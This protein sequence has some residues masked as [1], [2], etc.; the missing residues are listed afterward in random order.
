MV[1]PLSIR[2]LVTLLVFGCYSLCAD[3]IVLDGIV[4]RSLANVSSRLGTQ[5]ETLD[6]GKYVILQSKWSKLELTRGSRICRFNGTILYF[7]NEVIEQ[8]KDLYLPELDWQFTLAPLLIS[9]RLSPTQKTLRT[10]VL[11]PGH[12]G[13]DPGAINNDAG[14]FEKDLTLAV[15]L[16]LEKRLKKQGYKVLVTR[17]KDTFLTLQERSTFASKNKAD[18]FISIHFN[19]ASNELARGIEVFAYTLLN[20]PSTHRST[21]SDEDRIFRRANRY[22]ALNILLAYNSQANLIRVTG[23][24]DRG[25]KRARFA[26]IEDIECPGILVELG[27]MQNPETA[28]KLK[29]DAYLQTLAQGLEAGI[30]A[31]HRRL[32]SP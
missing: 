1:K 28:L 29:Q 19:S 8:N 11:D 22:D 18:L 7:G 2:L 23:E 25:V 5:L 13:K 27:F 16:H 17:R 21:I 20:Q 26:V 6:E 32:Q 24:S 3:T 14:L 15:T 30:L 10:V 9:Q 12:G 31:Y 4:Y